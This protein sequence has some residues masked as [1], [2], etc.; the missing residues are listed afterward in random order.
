MRIGEQG[1][2]GQTGAQGATGARGRT[3]LPGTE[4]PPLSRRTTYLF[5]VVFAS[6]LAL[7]MLGIQYG[8]WR[9]A[10]SDQRW[11]AVIA[12][13]DNTYQAEP[14]TTDTGRAMA[15]NMHRLRHDLGCK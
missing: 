3:G 12:S 4:G 2:R 15:A 10:Q 11:C 8:T 13:S 14:P 1:P 7:T 5:V 6:Q 9:A